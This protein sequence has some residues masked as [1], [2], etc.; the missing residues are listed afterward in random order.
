M[1]IKKDCLKRKIT[2]YVCFLLPFFSLYAN[3]V[4]SEEKGMSCHSILFHIDKYDLDYELEN[5]REIITRID[6]LI[7]FY[8]KH[9]QID[10]LSISSSASFD[11]RNEINE[12]LAFNRSA[13][14]KKYLLESFPYLNQCPIHINRIA[15]DWAGFR[16]M[17]VADENVPDKDNLLDILA[18]TLLTT[19]Q[20]KTQIK[21]LVKGMTYR[22][23]VENV[24]PFQRK[25]AICISFSSL[26]PPP[27]DI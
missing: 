25:V 5:N 26:P 7:H 18:N 8:H 6:S 1:S 12:N 22:Y 10:S 21:Q 13:T 15:E 20:K 3:T 17:V 27:P 19:T 23:L 11:G 14:I 16:D 4:S 9:H 24:L 2:K